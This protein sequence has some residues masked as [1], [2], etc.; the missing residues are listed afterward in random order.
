MKNEDD[1]LRIDMTAD[2]TIEVQSAKQADAI[3]LS[4]LRREQGESAMVY[5]LEGEDQVV[6]RKIRLGLRDDQYVQ[7]LEGLAPEDRIVIGSDVKSAQAQAQSGRRG[8][9]IRL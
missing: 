8:G 9:G 6:E 4:A 7:V 5:V 1:L 3:P 2:V